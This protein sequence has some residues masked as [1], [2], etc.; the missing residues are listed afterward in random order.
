MDRAGYVA[1]VARENLAEAPDVDTAE[2]G[3]LK[4]P[5]HYENIMS[6]DVV[7]VG[8]GIVRGGVKD[9]GNMLFTQEFSAP[10]RAVSA[11][12]V[13]G[14][15]RGRIKEAR[16]KAG[17]G[18]L[19]EPPLLAD[20][21]RTLVSEVSDDVAQSSLDRVASQ[22]LEGIAKEPRSSLR[23]VAVGASRVYDGDDWELEGSVV[24]AS[25]RGVGVGVRDAKDERG[26]PSKIVLLLV[27]Q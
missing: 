5:H 13:A 27:G 3:L 23:G 21:A 9:P 8:I 18:P 16:S 22:A 11:D 20:L 2:D 12:D 26:R 4:S 24:Q 15:V 7:K 19:A 10:A 6:R 25:A 17:L 14:L 1:K